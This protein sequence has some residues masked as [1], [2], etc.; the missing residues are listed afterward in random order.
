MSGSGQ[1]FRVTLTLI[2]R[3][4][5]DGILP[6]LGDVFEEEVVVGKSEIALKTEVYVADYDEDG[7]VPEAPGFDEEL[8]DQWKPFAE[9]FKDRLPTPT[10]TAPDGGEDKQ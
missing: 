8:G 3:L 5:S 2:E 1:H 7:N 4:N 10:T 6:D 9:A